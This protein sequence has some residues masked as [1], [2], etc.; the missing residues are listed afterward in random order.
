VT[1]ASAGGGSGIGTTYRLHGQD[2]RLAADD[3]ASLPAYQRVSSAADY[4]EAG[5]PAFLRRQTDDWMK[6]RVN[7]SGATKLQIFTAVQKMSD[8]AVTALLEGTTSSASNAGTFAIFAPLIASTAR[9]AF[10]SRGSAFQVD[11]LTPSN[12]PAPVRTVVRARGEIDNDVSDISINGGAAVSNP[13]DQGSGAYIEQ[14]V[15][16]GARAGTSLFANVREY[17]PPILL[18]M[19]PA[20]PGLSTSQVR[21][22]E[23]EMNKSI[24]AY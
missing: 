20:D 3:T 11:V 1:R 23:R 7:P 16:I 2:F 18:F 6:S 13:S 21:L 15:F 4:D 19:Q 14:D 5:F 12:V 22:I 24:K 17:T 9:I 10:R 8:A